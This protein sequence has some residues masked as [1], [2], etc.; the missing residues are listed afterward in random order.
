MTI[1]H[2]EYKKHRASHSS[3]VIRNHDTFMRWYDMGAAMVFAGKCSSDTVD[4][5]APW[6]CDATQCNGVMAGA[7]QAGALI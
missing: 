7:L 2:E 1:D 5:L 4:E 6:G 3:R